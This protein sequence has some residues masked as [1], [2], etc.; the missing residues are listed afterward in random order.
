MKKS[1]VDLHTHSVLSKHA[2]SSL[3]ENI[4]Y[5]ADNNLLYYGISEHQ[6]DQYGVGAHKYAFGNCKRITPKKMGNT[7]KWSV[8]N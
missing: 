3:T 5:A 4:E 1:F 2:Y 8:L 7:N 6:A